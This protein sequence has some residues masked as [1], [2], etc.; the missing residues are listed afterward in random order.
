MRM[1]PADFVYVQLSSYVQELHLI[2][3]SFAVLFSG[4][5]AVCQPC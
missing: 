1:E 5:T 2:P 3:I 4:G